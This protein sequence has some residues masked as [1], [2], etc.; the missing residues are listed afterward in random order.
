MAAKQ[1]EVQKCKETL[2]ELLKLPENRSCADCGAKRP[3]WTSTNIGVFVCIRCSGIHRNLG[4]HISFVK[5]STLDKWNYKLLDKFKKKGGNIVVN[6]VY[7]AKLP[8][9]LKPNEHT[10][11]YQLEQF[12][13]QK[14]IDRKWYSEKRPKPIKSSKKSKKGK[15]KN[16]GSSSEETES[17]ESSE[18][19][20]DSSSSED[21]KPKKR[22]KKAAKKSKSKSK[23]KPK[24]KPKANTQSIPKPTPVQPSKSTPVQR[25]PVQN[26]LSANQMTMLAPQPEPKPKSDSGLGDLLKFDS[27]PSNNNGFNNNGFASNAFDAQPPQQNAKANIMAAFNSSPPSQNTQQGLHGAFNPNFNQMS[28]GFNQPAQQQ[29]VSQTQQAPQ[30]ANN[31]GW[32][33]F[34]NTAQPNQQQP[35]QQRNGNGN[36]FM[37][38]QQQKDSKSSILGKYHANPSNEFMTSL[39]GQNN[40]GVMNTMGMG[41]NAQMGMAY[42]GNPNPMGMNQMPMTGMNQMG[43][44]GNMNQMGMAMGMGTGMNQ[45]G[46]GMGMNQMGMNQMGMNQM[47]QM[48]MGYNANKANN[49]PLTMMGAT[50]TSSPYGGYNDPMASLTMGMGSMTA[51]APVKKPASVSRN[52]V[53][54]ASNSQDLFSDFKIQ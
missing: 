3:T 11:T 54:T 39:P 33:G 2:A 14:Y 48:P 21:A 18:E 53:I 41:M 10:E 24:P 44:G 51:S 52:G 37:S 40:M 13:R 38:G 46:T 12:I 8:Q 7:E 25:K 26:L 4:V 42:G 6:S 27:V 5:S 47:N 20:E 22:A 31:S 50:N 9:A 1:R 43:Y 16:Y 32:V 49:N 30:S 29:R 35:P 23:A 36:D 17:E 28:N 45:M 15:K 19:E 34:N